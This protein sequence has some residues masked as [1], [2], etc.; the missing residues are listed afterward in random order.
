MAENFERAAN[1]RKKK[2]PSMDC[3]I[4]QGN[5]ILEKR[6]KRRKPIHYE[7]ST[8]PKTGQR[9]CK[10]TYNPKYYNRDDTASSSRSKNLEEHSDNIFQEQEPPEVSLLDRESDMDVTTNAVE[11]VTMNDILEEAKGLLCN[12]KCGGQQKKRT[13][14]ER[15]NSLYESWEEVRSSLIEVLL[16]TKFSIGIFDELLCESCKDAM[17]VIGCQDCIS[18]RYVCGDCD[19]ENHKNHPFHD[20]DAI[21]NGFHEPIP[22]TASINSKLE[23]ITVERSL[24]FGDVICPTCLFP[25]NILYDEKGMG[26]IAVTLK[27]RFDISHTKYECKQCDNVISSTSPH[28]L[29]QLGFWPGTIRDMTYVFHQDLFHFWDNL[30]K[31]VPGISQNSFVKSLEMFSIQKGRMG[32]INSKTFGSSFREWKYCQ[33]ELNKLRHINWMECPACE[34]QQ[35]SVHMDGNMK[36]YRY[37]SAGI[38]KRDCYYGDAFIASNEKVQHHLCKIYKKGKEKVTDDSKCGDSIWHAAGNTLKKKKI[39][40]ETGLEIAGCRHSVAQHAV[41]MKH[42]EVYGYAH[43]MQKEY[44][45]RRTTQFF[46]YDVICKYWPWLCKND[47]TTSQKM[48]P[49]LSV[50]HAKAHAWYCQVIW[51]GRWQDGAS[52]TTGEEVEQINS[53]FSRLGCTTKHMLPEGREELLTEHA[54]EWNKRKITKLSSILAKRYTKAKDKTAIM[55]KELESMSEKLECDPTTLQKWKEDIF[56]AAKLDEKSRNKRYSI[57]P[58]EMKYICHLLTLDVL[59]PKEKALFDVAEKIYK[60]KSKQFQPKICRNYSFGEGVLKNKSL[61]YLRYNME[62]HHNA[63]SHL[64][65]NIAKL[66]GGST[67]NSYIFSVS[68]FISVVTFKA[69]VS[70]RV[71]HP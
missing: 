29:I 3:L 57:T 37:K 32:T 69:N 17:A 70:V 61:E 22:P 45:L 41:S 23:W 63:I 13:W 64:A 43:Y 55:Q 50:M 16:Q 38:R 8:D 30:Q 40:D 56:D 60:E 4:R 54:L 48:K 20:R 19:E 26:C 35:H 42:G 44:Y 68:S 11:D 47:V 6:K 53:H 71:K 49:A 24:P 51:G 15:Q 18:H 31:I 5:D 66:A 7:Y 65:F 28:V 62:F 9:S 52:A 12:W 67:F 1:A 36:L 59:T 34:Q 10:N 58:E 21:L 14:H 2:L 46:W 27:G 25:C 33:Y 39:V